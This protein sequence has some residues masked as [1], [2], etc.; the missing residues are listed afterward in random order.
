MKL[1]RSFSLTLFVVLFISCKTTQ[2]P[3]ATTGNLSTFEKLASMEH[4]V[5]IEKRACQSFR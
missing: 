5:S 4:V 3:V 2:T 1:F